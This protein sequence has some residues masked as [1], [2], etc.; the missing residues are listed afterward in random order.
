MSRGRSPYDSATGE[1]IELHHIGQEFDSPYAEL[2]SGEHDSNY[3]TIHEVG[4]ESWRND[5]KLKNTY[6]NVQCPNHWIKRLEEIE[7]GIK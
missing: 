3:S 5:A 1:R 7:N 4:K 2:T 6:N